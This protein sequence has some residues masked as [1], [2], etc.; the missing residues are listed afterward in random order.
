MGPFNDAISA[1]LSLP[2]PYRPIH[3]QP[4]RMRIC[5]GSNFGNIQDSTVFSMA[6]PSAA[7]C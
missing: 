4:T 1:F 7:H 3:C 2:M 5:T 6:A